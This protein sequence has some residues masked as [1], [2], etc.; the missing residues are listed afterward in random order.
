M[1][2]DTVPIILDVLIKEKKSAKVEA[3]MDSSGCDRSEVMR[4]LNL[5]EDL[6]LITKEKNEK[7]NTMTFTLIKDIKGIHLAKAAQIGLDLTA[8]EHF[9]KIDSKEKQ[10]ALNLATQAEKIKHLEVNKRKPLLQKR[11]YLISNKPDDIYENLSLL[12]EATNNTLYEYIEE[13]AK[14]DKHLKLL[15]SMHEEAEKSLR[16]H[17]GSLK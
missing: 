9:F 7:T 17:A 8:F 12:L 16:D 6:D 11:S 4:A 13:L 15:I 5:L 10:L 14:K 3:L 2:D 1:L